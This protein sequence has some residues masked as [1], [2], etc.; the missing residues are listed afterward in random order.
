METNKSKVYELNQYII[1]NKFMYI[2]YMRVIILITWA[3]W[4]GEV[5]SVR[6][7]WRALHD[8]LLVYTEDVEHAGA[9]VEDILLRQLE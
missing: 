3:S 9:L 2:A 1:I 6:I 7:M 4:W 8:S 5:S